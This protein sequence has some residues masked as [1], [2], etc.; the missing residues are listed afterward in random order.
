MRSNFE[1]EMVEIGRENL[2]ADAADM[3]DAGLHIRKTSLVSLKERWFPATGLRHSSHHPLRNLGQIGVVS[4]T[5]I[6]KK[7]EVAFKVEAPFVILLGVPRPIESDR[8]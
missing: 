5:D 1:M 8:I 7:I 6:L 3:L 2:K 4:F